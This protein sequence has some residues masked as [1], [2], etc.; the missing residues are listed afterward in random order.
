VF[1]IRVWGGAGIEFSNEYI[2]LLCDSIGS[3]HKFLPGRVIDH[4]IGTSA[5]L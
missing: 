4:R 5:G 1:S 2:C 3:Q